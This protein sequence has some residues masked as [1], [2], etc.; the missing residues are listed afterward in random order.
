[1]L[2]GIFALLA[3]RPL[4]IDEIRATLQSHQLDFDNLTTISGS[5]KTLYALNHEVAVASV[6]AINKD[7]LSKEKILLSKLAELG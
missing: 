7:M 3:Q 1:M 4:P 6:S 2:D 5:F